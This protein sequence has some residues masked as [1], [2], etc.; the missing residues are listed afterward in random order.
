MKDVQVHL[1]T[2]RA[3]AADRQ[4]V[5]DEATDGEKREL[6]SRIAAHLNVLASEA[7]RVIDVG[8]SEAGSASRSAPAWVSFS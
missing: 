6:F 8:K 4:R 2:L 1:N 3:E 7:E 5:S